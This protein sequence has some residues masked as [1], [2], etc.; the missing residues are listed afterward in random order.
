MAQRVAAWQ[1]RADQW[2]SPPRGS[3]RG[4]GMLPAELLSRSQ[5]NTKRSR[6]GQHQQRWGWRPVGQ[7]TSAERE[8]GISV[9]A[10]VE[11]ITPPLNRDRSV[12]TVRSGGWRSR[13]IEREAH[14]RDFRRGSRS[15]FRRGDYAALSVD[16]FGRYSFVGS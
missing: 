1:A 15:H 16:N 3:H 8:S 11:P 9:E 6:P 12:S 7:R 5:W 13:R 10:S 14:V 2:N 4:K